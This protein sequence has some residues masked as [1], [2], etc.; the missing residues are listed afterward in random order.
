MNYLPTQDTAELFL[1]ILEGDRIRAEQE[2][3]K[4]TNMRCYACLE[5]GYP[6]D[7]K[8][9]CE[10]CQRFE[11]AMEAICGEKENES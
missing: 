6:I 8:G 10:H 3:D 2:L 5:C 4:I 1:A 11:N 9:I 7:Y